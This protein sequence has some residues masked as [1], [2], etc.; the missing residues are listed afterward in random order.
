M[1]EAVT[2]YCSYAVGTGGSPVA[3]GDRLG[4][5]GVLDA[6]A[7][8]VP[9]PAAVAEGVAVSGAAVPSVFRGC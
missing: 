5:A 7:V 8:A 2:R 3:L 9:L 4:A 1:P 6:G